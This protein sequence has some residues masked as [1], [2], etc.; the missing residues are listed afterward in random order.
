LNQDST[1]LLVPFEPE[2]PASPR[3]RRMLRAAGLGSAQRNIAALAL[4]PRLGTAYS[5]TPGTR[6]RRS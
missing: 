1:S 4:P 3:L 5:A 2:A 6:R